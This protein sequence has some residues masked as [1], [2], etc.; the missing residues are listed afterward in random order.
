MS[1]DNF[2]V[3]EG[4]DSLEPLMEEAPTVKEVHKGTLTAQELY[5][6]LLEEDVSQVRSTLMWGH[7]PA[8]LLLNHGK[9]SASSALE[10]FFECTG[11][12]L[13]FKNLRLTRESTG[14]SGDVLINSA[15][16][17]CGHCWD[18]IAP[19]LARSVAAC[20]EHWL[21]IPC[22]VDAI[23]HNYKMN[24]SNSFVM[25]CPFQSCCSLYSLKL[26]SNIAESCG[27]AGDLISTYY[28]FC[29][30]AVVP[31]KSDLAFCRNPVCEC[32]VKQPLLNGTS[33]DFQRV[34]CTECGASFCFKC[35]M[36]EHSPAT[37]LML[38][39]W[40]KKGVD[41]S[42][43]ANWVLANCKPCPGCKKNTEKNGGCNHMTC[44]G[45]HHEWCWVCEGSWTKH[46]S[47]FYQCNHF[48]K[49]NEQSKRNR[50]EAQDSLNK[51]IHYYTRFKNHERSLE[52]D[53]GTIGQVRAHVRSML[54]SG[55]SGFSDTLYLEETA[56]TLTDCRHTLTNTYIYAFYLP[57]GRGKTLF[58]Y[59]QGQLEASTEGLSRIVEGCEMKKERS[60]VVN[61]KNAAQMFLKILR[62]GS[63]E[64]L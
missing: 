61:Q 31:K 64:G 54:T 21:C 15:S 20:G 49:E 44:M 30:M 58:E 2:E 41:D 33:G 47:D 50:N 23:R 26:V 24:G 45:C 16:V 59:N 29:A 34:M 27:S 52:L 8:L 19:S 11:D 1:V 60:A 25:I 13:P 57:E 38:S 32:I 53:A 42:E 17:S 7:E 36:L 18:I 62:E 46:G 40:T 14:I 55:I 56:R 51:Y 35:G 3:F 10:S 22:W 5:T 39:K 6:L 28:R 63:Y 12:E 43:T 9:W 37:C 48:K 4:C